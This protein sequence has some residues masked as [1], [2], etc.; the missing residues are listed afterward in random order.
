MLAAVVLVLLV[1]DRKML[2]KADFML[3]LTFVAFFVF[4][5][6]L[7]RMEAVDRL[8]RSLLRGREYWTALLASQVISNVPAAL[9]LSGFTDKAGALLLGV[10]VGGLGTPIASLASL[11]AMKLYSHA[12]HADPG[13]FL[14]VFTA[15][16]LVLLV[17]L[18]LAAVLFC[19]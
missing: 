3:L 10:D 7:S 4:A 18:S 14:L 16:N 19:L 5:G 13:R 12:E 2:L 9:L 1:L 6:N 8:L 15:A 11:I 17:L